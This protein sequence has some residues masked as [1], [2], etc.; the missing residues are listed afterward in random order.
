MAKV[1]YAS[2]KLALDK[3]VNTFDFNGTQ[4]EVKRYLPIEDKMDLVIFQ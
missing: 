4:I 3:N 2:L 1:S